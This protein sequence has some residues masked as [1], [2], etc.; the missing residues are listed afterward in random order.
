MKVYLMEAQFFQMVG[1]TCSFPDGF[2]ASSSGSDLPPPAPKTIVEAFMA[3]QTRVLCQILQT[4]QQLAQRLQQQPPFG[5]NPDGPNL[6]AQTMV[7]IRK[8]QEKP[9]LFESFSP[10]VPTHGDIDTIAGAIEMLEEQKSVLSHIM[11]NILQDRHQRL[12]QT[13]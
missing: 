2:G 3:A 7:S 10:R 5:A 11:D 1:P 9:R 8:D 4:Q 6:V 13:N 12:S